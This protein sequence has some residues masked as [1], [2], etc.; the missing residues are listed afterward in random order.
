MKIS[1]TGAKNETYSNNVYTAICVS[2]S[3]DANN[4]IG[5][6][7]VVRKHDK[8]VQ[9]SP[10]VEEALNV[11]ENDYDD[12]NDNDDDNDFLSCFNRYSLFLGFL[13]G[14]FIQSASLGANYI[15]TVFFGHNRD[16]IHANREHI[17]A[18]SL[19][20][21]LMT[22][23]MGIM[24]LFFLRSLIVIYHDNNNQKSS[25]N[26]R[27]KNEREAEMLRV[28]LEYSFAFGA[29]AG[30]CVS[31]TITDLVL[32]LK[33]HAYHSMATLVIATVGKILVEMCT[34]ADTINVEDE[35]N[36][37]NALTEPLL[38]MRDEDGYESDDETNSP[39]KEVVIIAHSKATY[40]AF[41]CKGICI[42]LLVG[43][44][45][46]FSSLGASFLLDA[47][48]G[49]NHAQQISKQDLLIFSLA[50]SFLFGTMGVMILLLLRELV[51]MVLQR[52]YRKRQLTNAVCEA[53]D[54]LCLNL[55]F[56]FAMGCLL[57]VNSAWVLTDLGL[58]FKAHIILSFATLATAVLLCKVLAYFFFHNSAVQVPQQDEEEESERKYLEQK[59]VYT[60]QYV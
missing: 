41:K 43:F 15:L 19:A 47:V 25:S 3:S 10:P 58:G 8:G 50:W 56:F 24:I 60:I 6:N 40:A 32:G 46:Q 1:I 17:Y 51:Y 37:S 4:K 27:R 21:S 11:S 53:L 29:L 9:C 16:V 7:S 13:V 12:D 33:V 45:I 52:Q 48:F 36:N 57:G 14:C 34:P 59:M 26:T 39:S 44:F 5:A 2:S 49:E 22:A 42:G 54:G 30:V 38:L 23:V 18:F 28:H 35:N 55:E 31:W 20:W